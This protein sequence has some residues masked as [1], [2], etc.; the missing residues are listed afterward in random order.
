MCREAWND[1]EWTCLHFCF[2]PM[3][4][5]QRN[6]TSVF[7]SQQRFHKLRFLQ[8]LGC[9]KPYWDQARLS[10][11]VNKQVAVNALGMGKPSK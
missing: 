6:A 4:A 5:M 9:Q 8:K 11:L 2:F 1:V 3:K 7:S 10:S